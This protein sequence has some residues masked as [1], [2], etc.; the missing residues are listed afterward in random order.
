L[1]RFGRSEKVRPLFITPV[2][3]QNDRVTDCI[4]FGHIRTQL[5]GVRDSLAPILIEAMREWS[6]EAGSP[7]PEI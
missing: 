6:F 1:R 3:P 7:A 4:T 2:R 5:E